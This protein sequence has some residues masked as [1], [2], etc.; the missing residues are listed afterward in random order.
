MK[1][2]QKFKKLKIFVKQSRYIIHL[3][4]MDFFFFLLYMD[5]IVKETEAQL[6]P[7]RQAEFKQQ[8]EFKRPART[9][10]QTR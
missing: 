8:V 7:L 4:L 5:N 1:T 2:K 3:I 10:L 9:L 6:R